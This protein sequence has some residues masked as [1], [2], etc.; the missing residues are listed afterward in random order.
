M[1]Q[2]LLKQVIHFFFKL[3]PWWLMTGQTFTMFF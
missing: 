2:M 1:D 3:S